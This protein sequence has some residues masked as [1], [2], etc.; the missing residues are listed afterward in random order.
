M[1][2]PRIDAVWCNVPE[3]SESEPVLLKVE[4]EPDLSARGLLSCNSDYLCVCERRTGDGLG[5]SAL[6]RFASG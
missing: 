2:V 1:P 3:A 6:L 5:K 4:D